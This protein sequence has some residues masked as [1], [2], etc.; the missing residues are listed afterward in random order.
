MVNGKP[1]TVQSEE[2]RYVDV[3]R[4]LPEEYRNQR[5]WGGLSLSYEGFNR[6][7]WSQFRFLGVNGGGNVD[8]FFTVTEESRS[9]ELQAAWWMPVKS[10][11]IIALGNITDVA[12][13]ATVRF[14]DKQE[15]S[16]SLGPHATEIL[17]FHSEK[18][19]RSESVVINLTGATGSIVPTGLITSRD[20]KFNS[21]IRQ[22]GMEIT[23]PLN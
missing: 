6:E 4:L 11:A 3:K 12:T 19:E 23:R 10:E 18:G 14:S 2:I 17:R 5:N 21:V 22:N 7:M 8:E 15:R 16:V 1:V 9:D 20:G 13:S